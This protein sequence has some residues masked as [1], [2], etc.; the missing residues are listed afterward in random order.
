MGSKCERGG[1]QKRTRFSTT[2][3]HFPFELVYTFSLYSLLNTS[4]PLSLFYY[5]FSN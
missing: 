4:T 5:I 2:I 1:V 3:T